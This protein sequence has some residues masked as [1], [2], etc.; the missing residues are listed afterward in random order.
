MRKRRRTVDSRVEAG[1]GPG[2]RRQIQTDNHTGEVSTMNGT[3]LRVWGVLAVAAV[4]AISATAM[5]GTEAIRQRQK[6]MEGVR[7]G[8]MVLSAIAKKE[9]PFDAEVVQASGAK[10]ARHLEQAVGLFPEGSDTGDVQTWA[11]AEIWTDRGKFD[12]IFESSRQAAVDLQSVTEA[13][14]FMPGLGKLG[15]TCKSCHDLYR[16]PKN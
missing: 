4:V 9:K 5:T 10:I 3:K 16:L 6:E 11:K 13:Q 7:D 8:I 12:E 15:N 2:R 14:Q 1:Y